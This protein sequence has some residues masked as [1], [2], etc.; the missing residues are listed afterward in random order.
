MT[1][2]RSAHE[3]ACGVALALAISALS[4]SQLRADELR[5]PQLAFQEETPRLAGQQFLQLKNVR[6]EE[7]PPSAPQPSALL[8]FELTNDGS[9]PIT[10]IRLRIEVHEPRELGTQASVR[11]VVQP[12]EVVGAVT[13][14]P[15]F[16]IEYSVLFRNLTP[17][18]GCEAS[19]TVVSASAAG[20]PRSPNPMKGGDADG[21]S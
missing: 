7:P 15:G 8:K 13:I 5:G 2:T 12:F 10:D 4:S 19:V 9:V 17:D 14:E 16:T 1:R 18:C 6:F 21:G 3:I 11:V 20:P